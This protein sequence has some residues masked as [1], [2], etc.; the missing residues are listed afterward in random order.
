MAKSQ[1]HQNHEQY[2]LQLFRNSCQTRKEVVIFLWGTPR[3]FPVV[4]PD[5]PILG[6]NSGGDTADGL[7]GDLL[8]W[9]RSPGLRSDRYT[10]ASEELE[11]GRI[12]QA[13]TSSD[14]HR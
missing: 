10:D 4:R 6:G 3:G 12:S 1:D 2:Q 8:N 13:D 11:R 9:H 7:G 14:E 5:T